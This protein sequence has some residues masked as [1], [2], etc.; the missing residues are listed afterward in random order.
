MNN[1]DQKKVN[2]LT[3]GNI[4][5]SIIF[6]AV[7]ILLGNLLQSL[8]NLTDTFWVGR[9]GEEAVAAVSLSFPVIFLIIAFAGGIGLAGAILVAQ[10]KGRED[11]ENVNKVSGQTFLMAFIASIV[12]GAIGYFLAPGIVRLLGAEQEVI[13]GAVSYMSISFIGVLFVFGYAI[14]QS[15]ARGVGD[16]KTPVYIVLGTVLLNFLLDPLFIFG[17]GFI[18]GYGVGG[19]ALSTLGTQAVALM[20]GLIVLNTGKRGIHLKLHNFKPD[21]SLMKKIIKLGIPSSLEQ[22]S[23]SIGFILM[24]GIVASFGTTILASYGIGQQII[25]LVIIPA[26]SLSIANSTLVGQNI[27]AGKPERAEKIARISTLIGF[28]SLTFIGIILFIF[29]PSLVSIFVPGETEVIK[30]GTQFIRV[31]A[32]FFGFVG[33]NMS[34]FG[35]L[36]GAGNTSITMKIAWASMGIQV[37]AAYVLSKFTPLAQ[38]GLWLGFPISSV[39]G[40]SISFMIMMNGKWKEMK[41]IEHNKITIAR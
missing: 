27:G 4:L 13:P 39:I 41:I 15:L 29:A 24:V 6:L 1:M 37:V 19:A 8:Y 17:Y 5:K 9:L 20:A 10:Y 34:A 28:I 22:S 3:E 35:T 23:R 25:M 18:P 31:V 26:L 14:Y 16:A 32:L 38:Y 40:A 7:P 33:V 30:Y 36:R 21:F 11:S 2:L 12:L